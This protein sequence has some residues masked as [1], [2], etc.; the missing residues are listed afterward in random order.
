MEKNNCQVST[1]C[2]FN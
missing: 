1:V 2:W